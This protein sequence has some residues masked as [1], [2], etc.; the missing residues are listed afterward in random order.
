MHNIYISNLHNIYQCLFLYKGYIYS[1]KWMER[2]HVCCL[3]V[4]FVMVCCLCVYKSLS[5]CEDLET[6]GRTAAALLQLFWQRPLISTQDN[7]QFVLEMSSLISYK[8]FK[9][10]KKKDTHLWQ[11]PFS[12]EYQSDLHF[13]HLHPSFLQQ[14]KKRSKEKWADMTN[15]KWRRGWDD[16]FDILHLLLS[17]LT[18]NQ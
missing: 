18:C 7:L 5:K 10:R 4:C 11:V 17:Y 14:I 2:S 16:H 9:E 13:H 1:Y 12:L 6:P 8:W 3:Y 15:T